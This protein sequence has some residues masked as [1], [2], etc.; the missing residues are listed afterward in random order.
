[1]IGLVSFPNLQQDRLF[2]TVLGPKT[3]L[4]LL[5]TTRETWHVDAPL[6]LASGCSSWSLLTVAHTTHPAVLQQQ[7]HMTLRH[8]TL[9]H[10][11]T[12]K[13]AEAG[14]MECEEGGLAYEMVALMVCLHLPNDLPSFRSSRWAGSSTLRQIPQPGARERKHASRAAT[15]VSSVVKT[16][17]TKHKYRSSL[18]NSLVA[19]FSTSCEH[20]PML[21][22][23]KE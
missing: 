13:T 1:M 7:R 17:E 5:D 4:W 12:L 20:V 8:H 9:S 10:T 14:Q 3:R 15:L 21:L 19:H 16:W 23:A 22:C 6:F 2:H 18:S 11:Q